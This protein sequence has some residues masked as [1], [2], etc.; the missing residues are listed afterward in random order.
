MG[1]ARNAPHTLLGCSHLSQSGQCYVP[2]HFGS[3]AGLVQVQTESAPPG[4]GGNAGA[5]QGPPAPSARCQ[6]WTQEHLSV[7]HV[8]TFMGDLGP[9][10][11]PTIMLFGD[12]PRLHAQLRALSAP[13]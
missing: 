1:S 6:G 13:G 7:A 11:F 12:F 10:F 5:V 2:S 9:A 8:R 4:T 3:P